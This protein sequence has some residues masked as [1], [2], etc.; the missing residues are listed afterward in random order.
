MIR[1]VLALLCGLALLVGAAARAERTAPKVAVLELDG[2]VQPASLRYVERGLRLAAEEGAELAILELNTPGGTLV[3]LRAMTTVISQ[4]DV[5]VAV[6]VTPAGARAASAGFFLLL[7]ADVAAMAPGTN[8]GAAHPVSPGGPDGQDGARPNPAIAKA[9]ED[10]AALARALAHERGRSVSRA[11]DAVREARSYSAEEAARYGLIDHVIG[12]RRSLIEE[13]NGTSVQRLDGSTERL[14]LRGAEVQIVER[15]L[16][17]RLL[18]VI[19]DPQ[20]AYLLLM[21]GLLGLLVEVMSP[22]AVVPGVAGSVSLVV[23][24]YAF[25]VLPVSWTGGLL[26]A[27]AIGLFIAEAFAQSYGLLT[28]GGVVTLILGSSMLID[29]PVPELRI[30]LELVVPTAI[31][32]AAV[33]LLLATR[34]YRLRRLGVRTGVEALVGELGELVQGIHAPGGEGK[35]F[36]HGELW[37][38][39]ADQP[40]PD[41]KQ[42]RIERA[43][44]HRLHVAPANRAPAH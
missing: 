35:V 6:Y 21:F 26:I 17:E 19:A 40:L 42:V 23:A 14:D 31:L 27:I 43:V 2:A 24:L 11:E 25:S 22:G 37:N 41:G 3:S 28:I 5:P 8:T 33:S 44:G 1:A 16:A 38:A 20:V 36:V 9:T 18:M 12:D 4:S 13:L 30:G 15:S 39:T 7:A 32:L 10:A 29:A 34:A